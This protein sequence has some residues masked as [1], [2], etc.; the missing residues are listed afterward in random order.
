MSVFDNLN[1]NFLSFFISAVNSGELLTGRP[2][3]ALSILWRKSIDN[4]C[5][6]VIFEDKRLLGLQ[7]TIEESNLRAINVY[8]LY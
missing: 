8:L 6:G 3:G 4:M 1:E 2:Y 7:I 5:R